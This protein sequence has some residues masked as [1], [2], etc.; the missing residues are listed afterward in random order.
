M[1]KSKKDKIEAKRRELMI[2]ID[3]LERSQNKEYSIKGYDKTA[4]TIKEL[5]RQL[6]DLNKK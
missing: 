4:D 1:R 5:N 6:K 3:F 2:C